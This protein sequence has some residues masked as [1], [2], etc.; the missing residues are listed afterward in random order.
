MADDSSTAVERLQAELRQLQEE[1]AASRIEVAAL[2]EENSSLREHE[3]AL[4]EV[5]RVIAFSPADLQ[6]VLDALVASA[7][8]LCRANSASVMRVEGDEV[9]RLATTS[10]ERLLP[11][12]RSPGR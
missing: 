3:A 1:Y 6:Q 8:R 12:T 10:P 5:L 11:D 9:V 7:A 4:A 2:R